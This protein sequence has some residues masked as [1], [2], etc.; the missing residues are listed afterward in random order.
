MHSSLSPDPSSHPSSSPLFPQQFKRMAG[1]RGIQFWQVVCLFLVL[2]VLIGGGLALVPQPTQG[3]LGMLGRVLSMLFAAVCSLVMTR[4]VGAG[5][6]RVAWGC[7][8]LGVLGY[9]FAES[10]AFLLALTSQPALAP[11]VMAALSA[12]FYVLGATGVLLLPAVETT[13]MK[14]VYMLMDVFIIV[15]ALL[16]LGFVRMLAPRLHAGLP[17]EFGVFIVPAVDI[18][19]GLAFLVLLVRGVQQSYRSV[20]FLYCI[21]A[22]CFVYG[23]LALSYLALPNLDG[24]SPV[25][26]AFNGVWIT[27]ALALGLAPLSLMI[28]CSV[29]VKIWAG[30]GR[31]ASHF[32][33]PARFRWVGQLL[34]VTAPAGVL[35]G[36]VIYVET[37][38]LKDDALPLAV[39]AAVVV[40]F[41]LIRQVL[42]MRDL[43]DARIAT[44]RAEQLDSLKDQFI[45]SV[46]HELRTPLMTMKGYLTL[47]TDPRIQA[48]Q[49]KRL[50][51]LSRAN[52]SC[53]SLVYLVQGI[54]DTRRIDQEANNFTPEA[55]RVQEA[56][57]AAL[58]LVDPREADTAD[59]QIFVDI[60]DDLM[61]W[62]EL[63]RV[64][65]ILTNLVSNAIKYSPAGTSIF[66]RAH[67][68]AERTGRL[69]GTRG[70]GQ[71]MVEITVR[72]EGLG[73]PKE[74]Q[75]LLFR[76]FVRLPRDIASTVHGTG[77]GLY[78]C[79]VFAEAMGGA[80]WVESTGEPGAGSTFH[81][82]LPKPPQPADL[83]PSLAAAGMSS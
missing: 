45:T 83:A 50:D 22:V 27:G 67:G 64:Q 76:R 68:F 38:P 57:Q 42:T 19:A 49:E 36:L 2:A 72:D 11:G 31:V 24:A 3:L 6:E 8:S 51:M 59:R 55:I 26:P 61:V 44:E 82:R 5:R 29:S 21:T 23:D 40:A 30:V 35:F 48:P 53:E 69:L 1:W 7:I 15:G 66:I 81:V 28:P 4:H 52:R 78:L 75:A 43:V 16:G 34:L 58:S 33:L 62:G 74:Q 14:L 37:T 41:I 73:I 13:G 47:L 17:V 9:V 39:L 56:M 71:P 54:L 80:I 46:N 25:L 20:L 77:L 63:V 70:S 18:A 32:T 65:Q 10:F 12:P 79:R 60:P